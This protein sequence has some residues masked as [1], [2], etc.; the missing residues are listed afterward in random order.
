MKTNTIKQ[1][2][3][4]VS[5]TQNFKTESETIELQPVPIPN[6]ELFSECTYGL[7]YILDEVFP[8]GRINMNRQLVMNWA[9]FDDLT[10]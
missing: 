2:T 8:E 5:N 3:S 6:Q 9:G 4:R 10:I 7:E 1:I